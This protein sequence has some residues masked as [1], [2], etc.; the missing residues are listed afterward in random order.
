MTTF[1]IATGLALAV[2]LA[3]EVLAGD[4]LSRASLAPR[5]LGLR[6]LGYLLILLFWFAFSWRPWL[7][8]LTCVITVAILIV[9]SRAKRSV[10]GEPLLFSDFALLPQVPRHPQLYYIP[11]LW[12]PRIAGP[13]LLTLAVTVLWYRT[14]PSVLPAATLPRILALLG[15]PLALWLLVKAAPR[16]PLAG[17]IARWFPQPDLEADVTRVGLPA[18]LLGYTARAMAGGEPVPEAPALPHGPGDDVVVVIQLE[19]FV[20]P[21]RLGGAKLPVMDLFRTRAA[22]YGRLRVPAHGAYTMRSEHAVL[23]GRPSD[24]LGFGRYDPYTSRSGDEPTSLAR[25]ARGRGY[26]T[27]FLHPFHRDFFRRARV[28]EAFGFADLVMGEAFTETPRVGPYVGDIA[29]G[30][31]L[32]AEVRARQ[33]PLFLFCV[34]MENHGPWKPG[35][36]PGIDDPQAQYLHHVANTGQMVEDIVAGLDVIARERHQTITLCVFGDHA[37]SLPSCKPGF[38]GRTTDYALFRFGQPQGTP[39][40]VDIAADELGRALRGILASAPADMATGT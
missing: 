33:T 30:D 16:P 7:A 1:L 22:Q 21:E 28:M 26:G 20:D 19:S 17:L 4:S 24:S 10:I 38:G 6:L 35:R 11:P 5:D 29:L 34:T 36:L 12:D 27:L 9:V 39:A 18:S 32:L 25:L 13:V 37:P 31:R 2:C 14:E 40:Q 8:G 3:L 15:L 23:T